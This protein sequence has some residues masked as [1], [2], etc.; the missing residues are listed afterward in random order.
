VKIGKVTDDLQGGFQPLT[1]KGKKHLVQKKW[2]LNL[3]TALA[4]WDILGEFIAQGRLDIVITV[5]FLV[6]ILLLVLSALY[7]RFASNQ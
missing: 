4:I 7:R 6:A 5:S 1:L 3:V 2:A